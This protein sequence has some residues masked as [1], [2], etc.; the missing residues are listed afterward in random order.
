MS[1]PKKSILKVK[2]QQTENSPKKNNNK[3][4]ISF[5]EESNF[6]LKIPQMDNLIE[7]FNIIPK[8]LI[9]EKQKEFHDRKIDLEK[10]A[11]LEEGERLIIK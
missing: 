3:E 7:L 10:Q 8:K 4:N 5:N 1:S 9:K 2:V 11:L 6:D